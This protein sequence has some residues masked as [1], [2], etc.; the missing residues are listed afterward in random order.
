LSDAVRAHEASAPRQLGWGVLTVSSS[1]TLADD[2]GGQRLVALLGEAGHRQVRRD[3]VPDD[4]AAISAAV[5][6]LLED[7]AVDVVVTTGGTGVSPSDVTPEAVAPLLERP[8]DGFG[9]LFRSL[10]FAEVGAAALLSRAIAG[11]AGRKAVFVLPGSPAAVE[12]AMRRLVLPVAAHLVGQL[13]R[14]R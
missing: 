7:E 10:S 4:A 9:E 11:V 3:L 8:L 6:A 1:R 12:L 5:A 14:V 13:R 2:G